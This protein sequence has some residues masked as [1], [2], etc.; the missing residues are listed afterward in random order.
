MYLL[1]S[2]KITIPRAKKMLIQLKE[3]YGKGNVNFDTNFRCTVTLLSKM[4]E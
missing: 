3:L 4:Q 1:D 2:G